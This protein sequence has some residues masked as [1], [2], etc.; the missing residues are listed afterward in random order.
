AALIFGS[1]FFSC[2]GGDDDDDDRVPEKTAITSTH[3]VDMMETGTTWDAAANGFTNAASGEAFLVYNY[4]VDLKN[5][6]VTLRAKVKFSSTGGHVGVGFISANGTARKGYQLLTGQNIKNL[7]C[8]GGGSGQGF[9]TKADSFAWATGTEYVFEVSIGDSTISYIVYNADGTTEL[10]AKKN[11]SIYHAESDIVYPAFGGTQA[12]NAQYS[13]I[14]V[15]VNGVTKQIDGIDEQSMLPTLTVAESIVRIKSTTTDKTVQAAATYNGQNVKVTAASAD[16]SKV[17][18]AV[19][20]GNKIAI[21]PKAQTTGTLITVTHPNVAAVKAQFTVVVADY[22]ET[23]AALSGKTMYPPAGATGVYEDATLR[24]AFD[25]APKLTDGASVSIFDADGNLADT[26]TRDETQQT[27]SGTIKVKDQLL[28]VGG[29]NVLITPHFGKLQAGKTYHVAVPNGAITGFDGISDDGNA[30]GAWKFTVRA[31]KIASSSMKVNGSESDTSADFKT[32]GGALRA[33]GSA[34][35][36]YTITVAD[37]TYYELINVK[38][39]ANVTIKGS[40]TTSVLTSSGNTNKT[41]IT[42]V[43]HNDWNGGTAIRPSFYFGGNGS[44]TLENVT[45]QNGTKR[46]VNTTAQEAQAEAI[47]FQSTGNLA[48]YNCA[49][50]SYQ[51]TVQVGNK[52]GKAW[53]YKCYIEGD[54][55]YLWGTADVA[56]FEECML[57]T[58]NDSA[59]T[60]KTSDLMV[61]RTYLESGKIGKGFVLLNST[62]DIESGMTQTFG[63]CAGSDNN[64]YDQ[65]AAVNV[66]VS[67]SG[68]MDGAFWKASN[69]TPLAGHETHVG[70]KDYKI[71]NGSTTPTKRCD[72]TSEIAEDLYSKEYNGRRTILNRV[73]VPDV[74][75]Y[76]DASAVWDVSSL[77]TEFSA[78]TD[79][80]KNNTYETVITDDEW[81]AAQYKAA[82]LGDKG[83]VQ[84]TT[85]E[86]NGM[87]LDATASGAKFYPNSDGWIQVNENSVAYIPV[88]AVGTITITTNGASKTITGGADNRAF[89]ESPTKTH[90]LAFTAADYITPD[91]KSGNYVKVTMGSNDYWDGVKVSYK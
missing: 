11:T 49:F 83:T 45:I 38:I 35:G 39:N 59:R 47:Y 82:N 30:E 60:T 56:L 84:N 20:D 85:A 23:N 8:T 36:D 75:K 37:G 12:A 2:G 87:I 88:K 79:A 48:A 17:E 27:D 81:T 77:E 32:V 78:T 54:V 44:L 76:A 5:D 74:K 3:L 16:P 57:K 66:T 25:S 58:L 31:A 24:L 91:G 34:T 69:Y 64:Y 13:D 62:L 42:Y 15:T 67:G 6:A 90:T 7:G 50:K 4:I 14:S 86:F 19:L 28:R 21:T 10:A 52:G 1:L 89:T 70:W 46:G 41:V 29:N 63:R 80:S 61:A 55:D 71:N 53:F 26:I 43:N 73:Y 40:D 9:D 18:V 33:I 22:P 65:C 51:D 68:T 72:Q